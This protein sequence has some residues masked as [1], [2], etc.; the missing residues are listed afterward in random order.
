MP[1]ANAELSEQDGDDI[2]EEIDEEINTDR[3]QLQY[4]QVPE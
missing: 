4:L 2:S 3:D 1:Q